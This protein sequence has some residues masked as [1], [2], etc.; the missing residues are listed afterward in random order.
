MDPLSS[1]LNQTWSATG[2]RG[3]S[4]G[5][6]GGGVYTQR[7][8]SR[9]E[10]CAP[11]IRRAR[12]A[13]GENSSVRNAIV[14]KRCHSHASQRRGE[15]ER[16]CPTHLPHEAHG[17]LPCRF[18]VFPG[19]SGRPTSPCTGASVYPLRFERNVCHG[20]VRRETG[21]PARARCRRSAS[22]YVRKVAR[23]S[24]SYTP[25]PTSNPPTRA[26]MKRTW[27]GSLFKG[28]LR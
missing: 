21:V 23:P 22:G 20:R 28:N 27:S 11:G 15:R 25:R 4:E 12:R 26:E 10:G 19:R 13:C 9:G 8:R 7:E 1:F 17:N 16:S 24:H 6:R 3:A 2:K 14:R 18:R 5:E